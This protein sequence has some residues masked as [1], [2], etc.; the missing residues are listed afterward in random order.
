MIRAGSTV[1]ERLD[2]LVERSGRNETDVLA[3]ALQAGLR[4][5]YREELTSAYLKGEI[6]REQLIEEMGEAR[7]REIERTKHYIDQDVAWALRRA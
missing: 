7:V 3:Q 5:L 4:E 1:R 2:Y 6:G